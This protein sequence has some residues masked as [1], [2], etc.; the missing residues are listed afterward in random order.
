STENDRND[1]E[2]EKVPKALES[3]SSRS[4]PSPLPRATSSNTKLKNDNK[5]PIILNSFSDDR[6]FTETLHNN[7]NKDRLN[8]SD[9]YFTNNQKF[10]LT[11]K[12]LEFAGRSSWRN[13]ARCIGRIN[14][15]KIKLFDGRHCTTTKEMFDL[16]CEHLKYATNGGNIRSA[17]TVF[18]QRVKEKH[19]MRIWNTQ[20]INYAGYEISETDT[21]GD[22]SQ[23]AF[24]KICEALGWKGKR[25]EFDALP[26]VLQVDGKK[27]DVY[28]IPPELAL[29]VEIEHPKY[30]FKNLSF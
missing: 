3:L 20:L 26:L 30:I 23:V 9:K 5:C 25:T 27:P 24:T 15:S 1:Q 2:S 28:E 29:Q 12:E 11:F 17:I 16:L 8:Q 10:D 21:I 7:S 6:S 22:K 19:D 14:W 13:A 18:R 4:K